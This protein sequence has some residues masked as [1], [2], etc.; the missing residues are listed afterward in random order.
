MELIGI[1]SDKLPSDY[2][3]ISVGSSSPIWDI[4]LLEMVP[5]KWQKCMGIEV[6]S[7]SRGVFYLSSQKEQS[8]FYKDRF[9]E[10][11]MVTCYAL[12]VVKGKRITEE[13]R[14]RFFWLYDVDTKIVWADGM[15][16]G[17]FIRYIITK[18]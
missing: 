1:L 17:E 10:F 7:T 4:I 9:D 5:G 18:S 8:D 12:R 6:K 13:E 14:W 3:P 11:G 2:C 15:T 16:L